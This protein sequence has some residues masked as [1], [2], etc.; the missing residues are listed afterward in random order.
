MS[1]A[2]ILQ[3]LAPVIVP[4]IL[5]GVK[6]VAPRLPAKSIPIAAPFLGSALAGFE[7]IAANNPNNLLLGAALGI[8]GIGVRE[9]KDQIA[10][11]KNGG[12]PDLGDS[13]K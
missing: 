3:Y 4:S 6:K 7:A 8:A 13:A 2:L 12:W 5:A 11:A 9:L 10:P 1:F